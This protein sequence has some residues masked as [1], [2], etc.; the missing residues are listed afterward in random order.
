MKACRSC[1]AGDGPIYVA[2]VKSSIGVCDFCP[3][4][5]ESKV[6]D[7]RDWEDQF[8]ALL[9]N[10]EV[11]DHST[12][13]PIEEFI[14]ADWECFSFND[15]VRIRQFLNAAFTKPHSLLQNGVMSRRMNTTGVID[16]VS[17]WDEFIHHIKTVN[18]FFGPRKLSSGTQSSSS[19]WDEVLISLGVVITDNARKIESGQ[20]YYRGRI[21]SPAKKL[22]L[23]KMGMPPADVATGGRGNPVG[24]P[25]LYLATDKETCAAECRGGV[26]SYLSIAEYKTLSPVRV[27]DL[28]EIDLLSPFI[29]DGDIESYLQ[30]RAFLTRL[31]EE[32]SK[33][34]LSADSQMDYVS[35]Q[36]LCEYSKYLGL[37][38]VVY[39]STLSASG[40]NLVLFSDEFVD[41]TKKV[42]LYRVVKNDLSVE[43]VS[44]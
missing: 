23:S 7:V 2:T 33:P 3:G 42:Q 12:G 21:S 29:N 6:W 16:Y 18:R 11:A 41:A 15:P 22:P 5:R 27:L 32:I 13:R 44:S 31:G 10:Y 4:A 19:Y 35:T 37:D 30:A 36:F 20:I 40:K 34:A 17:A 9:D 8:A 24:I 39:P 43:K 26:N 38:G 25:H 14:A 1:F 28:A